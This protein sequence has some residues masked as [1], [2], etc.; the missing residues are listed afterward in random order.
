M[1]GEGEVLLVYVKDD[2]FVKNKN[3]L[4]GVPM[5][6]KNYKNF[7]NCTTGNHSNLKS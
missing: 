6:V 4:V 2:L 1:G 3:R 7:N 5:I